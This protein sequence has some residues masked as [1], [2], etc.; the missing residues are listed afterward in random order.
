MPARKTQK[1]RGFTLFEALIVLAAIALL[2]IPGTIMASSQLK[3]A[4]DAKRKADLNR[5]KVALYDYYFDQDCFPVTLPDCGQNLQ[6]GEMI[7]LSGFPCSPTK[8]EYVYQIPKKLEVEGCPQKF[9]ALTNLENLNDP[10]V[11]RIGC[12]TGCGPNCAYNYGVSSTNALVRQG[13]V[14]YFACSPGGQ[15]TAY[16]EPFGSSKCPKAYIN[17]NTCNN[18]CSKDTPKS[19]RCA[20]AS[21]KQTPAEDDF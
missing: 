13:C 8:E 6:A 1:R 2:T 4:R 20:N 12:R 17:D 5:I 3:K 19:E 18:E 14:T 21:G 9:K 7:Y 10:D 15:C 11:D 16:D